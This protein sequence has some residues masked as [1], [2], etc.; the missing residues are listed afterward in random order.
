MSIIIRIFPAIFV[1]F[2]L[3]IASPEQLN[4]QRNTIRYPVDSVGFATTSVQMDSVMGRLNREFKTPLH[5]A[6]A[7]ARVEPN[8]IWKMAICPHDDYAY[9]GW[10]YPLALQNIKANTVILIGVA[11]KA[12]TM[13]IENR[14]V[15]ESFRFWKG[16]YGKVRVS[17]LRDR[18]LNQIPGTDYLLSDTLHAVEHSLEA[19]IPFLQ[20]Y[21]RKVEI[22]PILIPAMSFMTMKGLAGSLARAISSLM[23]EED[24][25][26][27]KDIAIVISNDA[28]HYGCEDW[29][30]KN[31]APFGCDEEGYLK[32]M[33]QEYD[34]IEST[35]I[36]E[37]SLE[38]IRTLSDSLV[39]DTNFREYRRTWC[40]RYAL[41]FGLLTGLN[42]Q[43]NTH[44]VPLSGVMTGY[45][46]SVDHP[47][48]QVRDLGM[49]VT[50]P[51]NL[52]HWVGYVSVGY[53]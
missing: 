44:T 28:I 3:E 21:N 42:L 13:G 5:R 7:Q 6:F 45:S 43:L 2:I 16:P 34:L 33:D 23:D 47:V 27:M 19:L 46:T 9:A 53:R 36:G 51:A 17:S 41:P 20:Y 26:W 25:S 32:A 40:G 15:F 24:L 30:G 48:L 22:I 4:A 1:L 12:R 11:H 50:A 52:R 8:W 37:L 14:M 10:M 18:I 49:G 29:S 39:Q 38:K 31:L 35:L